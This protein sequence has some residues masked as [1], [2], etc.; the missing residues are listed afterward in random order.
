MICIEQMISV[1]NVSVKYDVYLTNFFYDQNIFDRIDEW[2]VYRT[3]DMGQN[4]LVKNVIYSTN[5]FMTE[6]FLTEKIVTWKTLARQ[7]NLVKSIHSASGH[8]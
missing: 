4:V 5:F 3:N 8:K 1:K 6:T 2:F 7:K